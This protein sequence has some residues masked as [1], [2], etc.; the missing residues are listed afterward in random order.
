MKFI[1]P[2][3][4]VIDTVNDERRINFAT[5]LR[6]LE[7]YISTTRT[8]LQKSLNAPQHQLLIRHERLNCTLGDTSFMFRLIDDDSITI[9][10]A[11]KNLG[12]VLVDTAW[13]D[14]ELSRMLRDRQTYAPF[15]QK[16]NINGKSQSCSVTKL[17]SLLYD[18]LQRVIDRHRHI[19]EAWNPDLSTQICK[20]AKSKIKRGDAIVPNI[21]LLIKVHKPKGLCGRPIVPCTRWVTTPASVLA[22]HL[23]QEILRDA[24]LTHLVKDTKSF[25]NEL[26]RMHTLPADGVFLTGDIGSL[27][28]N[29][30]TPLGLR[31]V[32]EFLQE[33]KVVTGQI[34]WIMD[35]LSFVMH[36]SYLAFKGKV[37]H[38]RDG[39]AMGTTVAPTYANIVV[40][41]LE[42]RMLASFGPELILYRR[43]LDDVLVYVHPDHLDRVKTCLNGLHPKL[44]FEFA[45]DPAEAAFLDLHIFK[46]TRFAAKGL[47]DLRVHQ[48]KMNLYLYIPFHSYHTDAAKRSFIQTELMRYIRNTS[49]QRHYNDLKRIFYTRLRDRGYPD[50]FLQPV[51]A[52]I[53]Y[54]DRVY[55][56]CPSNQL[57]THPDIHRVPP[58]S[59]CLIRRLARAQRVDSNAGRPPVFVIPFSPLSRHISI[60]S[61]LLQHWDLVQGRPPI[62]AYQSQP[63]LAT[64]LVYQKAKKQQEAS[65]RRLQSSVSVSATQ[66]Q[67]RFS[68]SQQ[69]PRLTPTHIIH[70]DNGPQPMELS[71]Q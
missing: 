5:Q 41:M 16:V 14:A 39:T 45:S 24:N 65:A 3:A 34:E 21:Y 4:R 26:E 20:Y 6:C 35:L 13:Y 57:L 10:P 1:V 62:M 27:Y 23:L 50:R 7:Q 30:D 46:G 71:S 51:F 60:R 36:H 47:L 42:R 12:L 31:L 28:T 69:P 49:D 32:R 66:S 63:S 59:T 9:K 67:L 58:R 8:L 29:I 11:D 43:Y 53:F 44:V 37:Y 48:K 64:R 22:D 56:L 18:E 70:Q 38:Q 33:Q 2:S 17:P 15:N 40:Y 54:S 52:G 25:V 61:I 19:L 68:P 55:F